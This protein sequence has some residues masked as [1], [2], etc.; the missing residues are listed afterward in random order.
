MTQ[1]SYPAPWA[2]SGTGAIMFFPAGRKY[3][4]ENGF[5]PQQEKK[6]F[7]GITGAMMLVN[8][9]TADC[10]PY[11][12]ILYMPGL[13][14]QKGGLRLKITKIY[15]SSPESVQWGIKNWSIPKEYAD[16]KW[17]ENADELGISA[18]IKKKNFFSAIISK[19]SLK[20]PVSTALIPFSLLQSP[21]VAHN[22]KEGEMLRTRFSGNGTASFG[23]I[24]H[25]QTDEAM[26]PDIEQASFGPVI[27]MCIN[28]FNIRFPIAEIL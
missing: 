22:L 25:W 7:V 15:V 21:V 9:E 17:D 20:F 1:N 10:G 2:L 8:Y 24:E 14:W 11:K 27:S 26:F 13:F 28:P 19:K 4:L 3:A 18:A 5:I 6:D 23:S 12:E 16:I